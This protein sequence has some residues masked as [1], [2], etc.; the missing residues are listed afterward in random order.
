MPAKSRK[1]T[2]KAARTFEGGAIDDTD[3]QTVR[4]Y[5]RGA[6]SAFNRVGLDFGHG[7]LNAVD[8]AAF[9]ILEALKLPIDN[10]N[11]WM[12]ARLSKAER[13]TLRTLICKR[14][15]KRTPLAYLLNRAYIQGRAFYVDERVIVPRSFIAEI[16]HREAAEPEGSTFLPSGEEAARIL[17]LCT[18]SGCLAIVAAELYPQADICAVDLSKDALDVAKRNIEDYALTER[19]AC[20]EGDLYAPVGAMQFDLIIANPPYVAEAEMVALSPE[21]LAEPRLALAGGVDGFDIV[22]RIIEGA[23]A[24][25]TPEGGL[26]CETP[27][28]ARARFSGFQRPISLSDWMRTRST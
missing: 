12:D 8:E 20:F 18:G 10:I 28:K 5:F 4:D 17:D 24:H 3:F 25:L 9:L 15:E 11:P 26:I 6:I 22:R 19:I 2:Q 21:Y 13:E 27:K 16:L 14:I 1:A 7:A 23:A